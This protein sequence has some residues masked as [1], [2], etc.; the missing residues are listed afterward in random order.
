MTEVRVLLDPTRP[1]YPELEKEITDYLSALDTVSFKAL[2][3]PQEPGKLSGIDAQ[4]LVLTIQITTAV[5]ELLAAIMTIAAQV[6]AAAPASKLN[7][8][9]KRP[10]DVTLDVE[11][12]KVSLPVTDATA[13]KYLRRVEIKLEETSLSGGSRS[14]K[15]IV[16][17]VNQP[18]SKKRRPVKKGKVG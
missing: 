2:K 1:A 14:H 17:A 16:V 8:G 4:T 5:L 12:I 9:K 18:N 15:K 7:K 11:G 13:Q 10:K 3:I 6:N